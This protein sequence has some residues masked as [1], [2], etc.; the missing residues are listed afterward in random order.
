MKYLPQHHL[1]ALNGMG[2]HM[3]IGI[4]MTIN[5]HMIDSVKPI[6]KSE[7]THPTLYLWP[8]RSKFS[9]WSPG[10]TPEDKISAAGVHHSSD[11]CL[12]VHFNMTIFTKS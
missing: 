9:T 4:F 8:V 7:E 5:R 10:Y 6:P 11:F 12:G 1:I 3:G 2:G